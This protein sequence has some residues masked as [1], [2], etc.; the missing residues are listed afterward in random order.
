M[1]IRKRGK[2]G[3]YHAYFR[4]LDERADGSLIMVTREVCLHTSDPIAA[5]AL[6]RQLR[7]REAKH[8]AELRARAFARQLMSPDVSAPVS[9]VTPV[10]EHRKTRLR[11]SD[12]LH[13]AARYAEIGPTLRKI[14]SKFAREAGVAYMDQVTPEL[15][16]EYLARYARGK[17]ANNVRGAINRVFSLSLLESGLD[18][19]PANLVPSRRNDSD[20][21]RPILESE[22]LRLYAA[23]SDPWRTALLIGWHT[24]LRE[25]DVAALRWSELLVSPGDAPIV[26]PGKTRRFRRSV[27]IPIHPQLAAALSALPRS[28]EYVLG[29]WWPRGVVRA[30]DRR[31]LAS[32]FASC[33]VRSD[34]SG[35]VNF[36]SLRD[37]FISRMDAAGI[38]RHAIRGIV[39]HVS[40]DMT[41]LYSHD[42]TTARRILDLPALPIATPAVQ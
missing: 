14:W 16:H 12:A 5:A 30:S 25:G 40:D 11:L 13:V 28:N 33:G 39:G 2:S 37:S 9:A 1:A 8:R 41:D 3:L 17:T 38:P 15:V 22:F 7:E 26:T 35:I 32:L 23:A 20:H 27:Q 36:N 29:Q 19:S 34:A 24:G 21:Q 31:T 42:L 18:R 10:L 4:G 6:D